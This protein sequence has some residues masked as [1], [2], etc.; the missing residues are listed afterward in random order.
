MYALHLKNENSLKE[1][2]K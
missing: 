1:Y 2:K